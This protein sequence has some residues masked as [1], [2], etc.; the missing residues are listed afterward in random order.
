MCP[1]DGKMRLAK[2]SIG[3]NPFDIRACVRT[4]ITAQ[5]DGK[6][7]GL[8]PFD[9]RACVRTMSTRLPCTPTRS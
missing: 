8:N 3:L 2:I 4:I 6:Y 9:I 5:R 1:D 7:V